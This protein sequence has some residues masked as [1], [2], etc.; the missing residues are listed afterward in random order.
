MSDVDRLLAAFESGS[1]LR[2]SPDSLNIIDLSRAIAL[3]AGAQGIEPTPRTD[4]IIN[5]IGSQEHLLFILADGLG[6][7]L[8][9]PLAETSFLSS[10]LMFELSTV[11]PSATAVALTSIRYGRMA[12]PSR[13]NRM[14]D[15]SNG[16]R[17]HR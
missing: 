16:N 7:N 11:F 12:L 4:R 5:S 8:I 1:L 2:P 14:V 6:M 17:F 9:E 10:H 13:G 15:P 3:T